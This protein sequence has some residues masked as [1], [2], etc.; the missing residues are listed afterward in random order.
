MSHHRS[1]TESKSF[2][3]QKKKCFSQKNVL[4]KQKYKTCYKVFRM[5]QLKIKKVWLCVFFFYFV[6]TFRNNF[7]RL[8]RKNRTQFKV[9]RYNQKV[10]RFQF[11]RFSH[12]SI[13]PHNFSKLRKIIAF[14]PQCQHFLQQVED[15]E[16]QFQC[17]L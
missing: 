5:T 12:I 13:F 15:Q 9:G 8:K 1:L 10:L 17:F 11:Y 3:F 6:S 7:T 14:L 16:A 2:C 4:A